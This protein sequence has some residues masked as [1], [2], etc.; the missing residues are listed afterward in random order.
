MRGCAPCVQGGP[1][2]Y[3]SL[4]LVADTGEYM[5]RNVAVWYYVEYRTTLGSLR[6]AQHMVSTASSSQ[7]TVNCQ[8][9]TCISTT[10]NK[11]NIMA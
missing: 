3:S 9:S 6:N 2:G 10:L 5:Y 11:I 7:Q 4:L 1:K 8:Q